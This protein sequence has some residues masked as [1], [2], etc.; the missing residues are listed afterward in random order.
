MKMK[1]EAEQQHVLQ[2]ETKKEELL[3]EL[4]EAQILKEWEIIVKNL[5][6]EQLDNIEDI[7]AKNLE[8]NREFEMIMMELKAMG[9]DEQDLFE[10]KQLGQEMHEFLIQVPNLKIKLEIAN[11]NDLLDNIQLYLLGLPNKLGPLGFI[12]LH[13]ILDG[14]SEGNGEIVD[15]ILDTESLLEDE[16]DNYVEKSYEDEDV[17]LEDIAPTFRMKRS[18]MQKVP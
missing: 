17:D 13:H 9:M 10:M 5:D 14:E 11:N 8:R 4:Q 15:V 3:E 1:K 16:I 6:N 12:A 18:T 2:H 7:L